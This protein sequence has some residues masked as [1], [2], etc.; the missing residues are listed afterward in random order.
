MTFAVALYRSFLC[1]ERGTTAVEYVVIGTVVAV[2]IFGTLGVVGGDL[3]GLFNQASN[4]ANNS[5]VNAGG[6]L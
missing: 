6:T 4:T 1:D 3:A 2:A 5:L